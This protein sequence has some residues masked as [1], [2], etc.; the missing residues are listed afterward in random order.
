MARKFESDYR[1]SST[2]EVVA[3]EN[4]FRQDVDLR[5]AAV[6]DK[7]DVID[8]AAAEARDRVVRYAEQEI[9]PK[10]AALAALLETIEENGYFNAPIAADTTA[11]FALGQT[12]ATIAASNRAAFV[13]SPWIVLVR[14]ANATDYA[15]AR[16][17][18]YSR[19]SGALVVEIVNVHGDPGV[20]ADVH[21]WA[22]AGGALSTLESAA[23]A[24]ADAIAAHDDR[25]AADADAAA[26]D[27]DRIA[28]HDDRL[29]A[30]AS[31]ATAITKAAEA[32]A[33]AAAVSTGTS[34]HKIPYLD[35]ANTWS[36][37]QNVTSSLGIN[38][39][40]PPSEYS[41]GSLFVYRQNQ[42]ASSWRVSVNATVGVSA[43][44]GDEYIGGTANSWVQSKLVDNNGSPYY[45]F[46]IGS[47]VLESRYQAP[48]FTWKNQSGATEYARLTSSGYLLRAGAYLNF[49]ST[50]G[51]SGYGLW[52]DNGTLKFKN[53]N[54]AW[55]A[56]FPTGA[57]IS[58]A[59]PTPA[60]FLSEN[61][62]LLLRADFPN[63]W[64]FAQASGMLTTDAAW[65]AGD[66]GKFSSGD[67][68]T[69]FRL[70]DMRGEFIRV[71]DD[72][73]GLD[74]GRA[75]GTTQAALL[76][77][78]QHTG[79]VS[80]VGDHQHWGGLAFSGDVVHTLTGGPSQI[81]TGYSYTSTNTSYAGGHNHTF[82]SDGSGGAE[83]RPRNVARRLCIKY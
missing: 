56:V 14:D 10:A 23:Q 80:W 68:V 61:G 43:S 45:A 72:G 42:N 27:G 78:H 12:T 11:A 70:P 33:A 3:S 19:S 30:D 34:G 75:L 7:Q 71:Y 21:V 50:S 81:V 79:T 25:L 38:S 51:S 2:K 64:T 67:G 76:E 18:S 9:A 47:G 49:G 66:H 15:V 48:L 8:E 6:E 77:W 4:A 62:A 63:L 41:L 28:V 54:G 17:I 32:T 13:P 40:N 83:T 65:L 69:T 60:G 29:A 59:G 57:E 37:A 39:S 52:D 22:V 73:R 16:R 20:Y 82:T 31:A 36:A 24:A 55:S 1:I 58:I 53:L 46:A 44:I 5:L 74:G 26:T 35:G